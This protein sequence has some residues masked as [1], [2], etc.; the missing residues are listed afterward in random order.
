MG[1]TPTQRNF[2]KQMAQFDDGNGKFKKDRLPKSFKWLFVLILIIV[3]L[4][5]SGIYDYAMENFDVSMRSHTIGNK[6]NIKAREIVY[7]YHAHYTK[8]FN[9]INTFSN[10][11]S[12]DL[13]SIPLEDLGLIIDRLE[14]ALEYYNSNDVPDFLDST[15]EI[16]I[17]QISSNLNYINGLLAY[18]V[19]KSIDDYNKISELSKS[20]NYWNELRRD[21][22]INNFDNYGIEYE[23]N[24]LH[25]RF[26]LKKA[27]L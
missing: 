21:D 4:Y 18:K 24:D 2:R 14:N 22:M 12:R 25:I 26:W 10:D 7:N 27:S 13:D 8:L 5:Y 15:N 6:F 19:S 17:N 20:Y 23:I 11:M 9:S 16:T 1:L 3:F